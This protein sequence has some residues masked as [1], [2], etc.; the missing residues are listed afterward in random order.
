MYEA[1]SYYH[2]LTHVVAK[3]Q[4]FPGQNL[5]VLI[6]RLQLAHRLAIRFTGVCVGVWVGVCIC[7]CVYVCI[8]TYQSV[9]GVGVSRSAGAQFTYFTSTKV[10]I[11]TSTWL[12]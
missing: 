9:T 10:Q 2:I 4:A 12:Y 5:D 11:L 3:V 6:G 8:Y 1:L 7:V